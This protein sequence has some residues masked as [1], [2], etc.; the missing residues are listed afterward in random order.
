MAW[1]ITSKAKYDQAR[2]LYFINWSGQ[3][4]ATD[5]TDQVVV[6]ASAITGVAVL[7]SIQW[8]RF[9]ANTYARLEWDA[10]TDDLIVAHPGAGGPLVLPPLFPGERDFEVDNNF[11]KDPGSSG[12]TGDI[13]LTTL[14]GAA[15]KGVSIQLVVSVP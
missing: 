4:D 5:L 2:K 8:L 12:T 11:T 7:T 6:D 14:G 3:A 10:T 15:G 9:A 1:T 13:V